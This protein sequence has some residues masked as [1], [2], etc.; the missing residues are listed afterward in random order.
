MTQNTFLH[1]M[2][3]RVPV[4]VTVQRERSE[5]LKGNV[6]PRSRRDLLPFDGREGALLLITSRNTPGGGF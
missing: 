4:T 1:M 6:A 5:G 3:H 2:L